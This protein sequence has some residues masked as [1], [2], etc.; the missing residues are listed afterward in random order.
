M[1]RNELLKGKEVC[2]YFDDGSNITRKDGVVIELSEN[3]IV[4]KVESGQVQIIPFSRIIRVVE[5][6][7]F[8]GGLA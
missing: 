6:T 7:S 2:I 8:G 1:D 3:A 4:F 5:K